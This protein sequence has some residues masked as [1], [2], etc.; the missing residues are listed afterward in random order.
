LSQISKFIATKFL[1]KKQIFFPKNALKLIYG[2]VEFPKFAG[3]TPGPPTSTG[4]KGKEGRVGEKRVGRGRGWGSRK[5]GVEGKAKGEGSKEER[6]GKKFGLPCSRQIDA[7]G[8]QYSH[9]S[10]FAFTLDIHS[11]QSTSN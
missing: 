9:S 11:S 3:R 8:T 5:G 7:T 1:K 10:R 4:G 2:N 6:R